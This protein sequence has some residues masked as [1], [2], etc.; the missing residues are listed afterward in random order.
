MEIQLTTFQS[1]LDGEESV[2]AFW[3]LFRVLLA[4]SGSGKKLASYEACWVSDMPLQLNLCSRRNR[5]G[6][7]S[8]LH[9]LPGGQPTCRMAKSKRPGK[10]ILFASNKICDNNFPAFIFIPIQYN[11]DGENFQV[12]KVSGISKRIK[13]NSEPLSDDAWSQTQRVHNPNDDPKSN[14]E[15]TFSNVNRNDICTS[16]W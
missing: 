2:T 5:L 10:S 12:S 8:I 9:C 11:F 16:S 6:D 14:P 7:W 3:C 1:E 13:A 4:S 15:A